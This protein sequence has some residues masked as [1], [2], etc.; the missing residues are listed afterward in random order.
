M[1]STTDKKLPQPWHTE[2]FHRARLVGLSALIVFLSVS[3][4]TDGKYHGMIVFGVMFLVADMK[5]LGDWKRRTVITAPLLAYGAFGSKEQ[6]QN[7]WIAIGGFCSML[8]IAMVTFGQEI[9]DSSENL[10]LRIVAFFGINL[11]GWFLIPWLKET[12]PM[13]IRYYSPSNVGSI[14]VSS[15]TVTASPQT[16]PTP[17]THS[18]RLLAGSGIRP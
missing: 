2:S 15:S 11:F 16:Q 17:Q 10:L 1:A 9:M 7:L 4:I 14:L 5:S 6:H 13:I 8:L 18:Q 12:L 3:A